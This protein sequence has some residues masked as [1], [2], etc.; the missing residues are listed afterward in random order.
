M[1]NLVFITGGAR[2]GKSRLATE[3]AQA[4][5]KRV[6]FIAT[7]QAL[8]KEMEKRINKHRNDRPAHWTTVE[9]PTNVAAALLKVPKNT[10]AVIIDC[11]TLLVTNLMLS[12]NNNNKVTTV[13][14]NMLKAARNISATVIIVSNEVGAGIVPENKMARDFRD[15]A[16]IANQKVAKASDSTYAMFAGLPVKLK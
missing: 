5:G 11:L 15:L 12:G 10:N 13:I 3:L 6:V 4:A 16:G 1:G 7:G 14:N 2:S 9:E 8:D